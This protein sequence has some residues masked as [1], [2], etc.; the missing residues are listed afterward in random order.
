MSYNQIITCLEQ[1]RILLNKILDL[2]KQIEVR[3]SQPKIVLDDFL[4]KRR[5]YM[6]R[7]DK[8]NHLI[9]TL[10]S[11]L[12]E[13]NQ[14][15][16]RQ[17]LDGAEGLQNKTDEEQQIEKLSAKCRMI[18]QRASAIDQDA[19]ELLKKKYNEVREKINESRKNGVNSMFY[20]K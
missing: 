15:R 19:N 12:S 4:D 6:I 14:K 9:S 3:C 20:R 2:T 13:D 1:K 10:Q 11:D 18:V 17:L 7:V 16:L 5:E 8:C